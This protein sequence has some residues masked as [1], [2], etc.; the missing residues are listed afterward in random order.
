MYDAVGEDWLWVDG[1]I[2]EMSELVSQR[3]RRRQD[4]AWR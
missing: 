1:V 2:D 4:V 3:K